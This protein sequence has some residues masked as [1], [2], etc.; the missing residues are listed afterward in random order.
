ML[1]DPCII[2]H[3]ASFKLETADGTHMLFLLLYDDYRYLIK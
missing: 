2:T 3:S 1:F